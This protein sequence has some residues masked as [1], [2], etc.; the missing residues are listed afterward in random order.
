MLLE[1]HKWTS[2]EALQDGIIDDVAHPDVMLD[3]AMALAHRLCPRAEGGVY[4]LLREELCG[5]AD[6]NFQHISHVRSKPTSRA[7]RVKL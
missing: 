1:G 5:E 6:R 7:P 4:G 3:S 2:K